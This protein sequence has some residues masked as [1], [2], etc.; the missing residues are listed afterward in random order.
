MK[1]VH[2]DNLVNVLRHDKNPEDINRFIALSNDK[3]LQVAEVLF[4]NGLPSK[5]GI[6]GLTNEAAIAIVLDR[7]E[8]QNVGEFKSEYNTAAIECLKAALGALKQRVKDREAR[9]VSG[10]YNK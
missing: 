8:A 6:N 7:L 1:N 10:T 4:Q 9:G 2:T 3:G 5:E